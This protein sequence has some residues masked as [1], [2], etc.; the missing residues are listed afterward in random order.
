MDTIYSR[1]NRLKGILSALQLHL[2]KEEQDADYYAYQ[3]STAS[4][5]DTIRFELLFKS[6]TLRGEEEWD[7][8]A[9]ER[10][11]EGYDKYRKKKL[12]EL[13]KAKNSLRRVSRTRT[14]MQIYRRKRDSSLVYELLEEAM[15]LI[16]CAEGL[17][18][19]KDS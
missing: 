14:H 9:Y 5:Y 2:D 8:D 18:N 7:A 17:I 10:L 16:A 1:Y 12:R 11:M 6:L 15:R 13:E 3:E 4:L 19:G